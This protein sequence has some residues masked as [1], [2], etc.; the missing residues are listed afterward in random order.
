[1]GSLHSILPLLAVGAI[2]VFVV[3]FAGAAIYLRP[4]S[5]RNTED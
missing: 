2:V 1:M 3:A 4:R 5:P